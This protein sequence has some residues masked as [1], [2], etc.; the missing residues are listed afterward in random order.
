MS[1]KYKYGVLL[2][3]F[4]REATPDRIVEGAKQSEAYGFD[5]VWVRDHLVFQPHPTED[6]N[7]THVDPFVVLSGIATVTKR[8]T[9][10]TGTLIPHRNPIHTALLLGSLDFLAGPNRILSAW[11][12]GTFDHEFVAAGMAGWDRR[13]VIEEQVAIMRKLWTGQSVSHHGKYYNFD[14]VEIHPVPGDRDIPIWYGGM[15]PASVRRAVEYCEGWVPG[16]APRTTFKRLLN[17]MQRLAD[18]AGKP[19]PETG[20]IPFVVPGRTYEEALKYVNVPATIVEANRL[21]PRPE[22]YET[23]DDIEGAVVAGPPDKLIEEVRKFQEAGA[24]HYVFDMRLRFDDWEECLRLI[25]E[26]VLPE[27]KRGDA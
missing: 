24:Q 8:I 5:S 11:G 19:L 18:E 25:G 4:G 17:R 14:D 26:E 23:M 20:I 3:H 9:L 22:G 15:S 2:P 10:A 6:Q 7:K 27:L 21:Y 16:R 13:E 1:Q 12:I